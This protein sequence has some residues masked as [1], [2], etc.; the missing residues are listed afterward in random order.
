MKPIPAGANPHLP[1]SL[2]C[3]IAGSSKL[4]ND[5]DTIT[6]EAKPCRAF[7]VLVLIAFLRKNTQAAPSEVPMNGMS[8]P[9]I[10]AKTIFVSPK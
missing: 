4:K 5:A 8:I 2:L 9:C 7:S 1:I 10:T 3:S 6:P